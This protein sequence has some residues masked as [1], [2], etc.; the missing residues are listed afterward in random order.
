[1]NAA[2]RESQVTHLV[3]FRRCWGVAMDNSETV[4]GYK[5]YVDGDGDRPAVF[6]AFLD[7]QP[8]EEGRVNGVCIPVRAEELRAL[9][10]RERNYVRTEVTGSVDPRPGRTWAYLGSD[11]GRGRLSQGKTSRRAVVSREYLDHVEAG[12][13]AL[14]DDEYMTFRNSTDLDGLPV[15]DLVRVDVADE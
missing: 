6:V 1:V 7:L 3:G 4:P 15:R 13:R 14:G 12:F 8:D 2:E 5:Y 10:A 11:P 9:D